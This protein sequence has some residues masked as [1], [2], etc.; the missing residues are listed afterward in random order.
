MQSL[1]KTRSANRPEKLNMFNTMAYVYKENGFGGLFKGVTPRMALGV[2]R[3]VCM[4]SLADYAKDF[5][6]KKKK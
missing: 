3:T 6:A 2:W 5:V 4:V 1:S